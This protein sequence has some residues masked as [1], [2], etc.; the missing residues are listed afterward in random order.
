MKKRTFAFW[1][2]LT[3]TAAAH[4]GSGG[5]ST[6]SIHGLAFNMPDIALPVFPD[7]QKSIIDFGAKADGQTVNT[8]AINKTIQAVAEQGGGRVLIP[9]G[10]W[11]TG[12]IT[13]QSNI[14]LHLENN[15]MLLFSKNPDDY[16]VV[17]TQFE[18]KQTARCTSP[19]SGHGLENI[20]ITGA[21]VIDGSGQAW[22]PV[23]KMKM[24]AN[25]WKELVASG[26][27]V[28]A[29]G[30]TWYP[31]SAA[32]NGE[33]LVKNLL[34]QAKTDPALYS[35]AKEYL[36]PVMI[37]L[38]R[39]K[40]VLLQGPTFQNSPA[41]NIHPFL[42]EDVVLRNVTVRNPWFSQNGDGLDVESCRRVLVQG[43]SFD[44][45]DDAICVK[46]GKDAEGRKLGRPCEQLVV[47]DCV[48]YHGHGGFTIGSE[49]SGGVRNVSVSNCTFIGTDMGLRFKSLRGRGGVV[50]NIFIENIY[51]TDIP[52]DAVGFNLFYSNNDP[53][54]EASLDVAPAAMVPVT[55][56]TP[57]FRK[58]YLKNIVCHGAARAIFLQGLPEMP[59]QQIELEN[60]TISSQSGFSAVDAQE[61][62][63]TGLN[64][65]AQK[66][67]V[68]ALTNS[69]DI[70]LQK[71]T[72]PAGSTIGLQVAGSG[73]RAI[74]L[75]DVDLRQ[76][77]T[78]IK[79]AK[80]VS[81]QAVQTIPKAGVEAS[82]RTN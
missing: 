37:S 27:V 80:E 8:N 13:L 78:P 60:V 77:L 81:S 62:K 70:T 82:C 4:G 64:L 45:G 61:I 59:I 67:P 52:T 3:V 5:D 36:R 57:S 53:L 76:A 39:C 75:I 65:H 50:E 71:C 32:M 72:I 73:S 23:K 41:W 7:Y 38:V 9:A 63:L 26:G 35:A 2:F 68:F 44:V 28:S 55:E 69:R 56:E 74:R 16:P 14:D 25:Q 20:A 51:M 48:V 54:T 31:S 66:S 18:G 34:A 42:C 12:P 40:K 46:S 11:V 19:I 29:D 30:K 43:C 24:T 17:I 49:M 79:L 33:N 1:L 47:R 10:L 58:I 6:I 22:R 21:G 15:A